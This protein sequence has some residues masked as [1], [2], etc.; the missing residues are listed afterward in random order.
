MKKVLI[1]KDQHQTMGGWNHWC[2]FY[3]IYDDNGNLKAEVNE[4]D[5]TVIT[6][7]LIIFEED[8]EV[9]PCYL[10]EVND[11]N[12][13]VDIMGDEVVIAYGDHFG[14]M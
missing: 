14:V 8:N 12:I 13:H 10:L 5:G 1:T 4:E 2:E 9:I 6:D 11:T 7:H 3:E